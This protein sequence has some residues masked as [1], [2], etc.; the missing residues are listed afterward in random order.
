MHI[1][2]HRRD[3]KTPRN[4]P[5]RPT[6]AEK[7]PK[8]S[9]KEIP[10]SWIA[11]NKLEIQ[12]PK[13]ESI[14]IVDHDAQPFVQN[15]VPE[16]VSGP[17]EPLQRRREAGGSGQARFRAR[18]APLHRRK[19]TLFTNRGLGKVHLRRV[20][21]WWILIALF[22]AFEAEIHPQTLAFR[23]EDT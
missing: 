20:G 5:H 13:L 21:S 22:G 6:E 10:F 17:Q 7:E 12:N 23:R 19:S 1:T 11:L 4:A 18:A 14:I 9:C 3:R 8:E 2:R 16:D 15:L